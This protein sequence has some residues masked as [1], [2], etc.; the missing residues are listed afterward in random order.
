MPVQGTSM[1]AM[2]MAPQ[3]TPGAA[4]RSRGDGLFGRI[5]GGLGGGRRGGHATPAPSPAKTSKVQPEPNPTSTPVVGDLAALAKA[6]GADGSYGGD[7]ART[8]AAL[9]ALI[10]SGH[11][12]QAGLRRRTVVKAARWLKS[13]AGTQWVDEVLAYLEEVEGGAPLK[14]AGWMPSLVAAAGIEGE[15]MQAALGRL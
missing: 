15:H 9:M 10:L 5:F 14:A 13:H 8:A 7:A 4:P 3:Q 2:P 11:T 1:D 6:Q 12:R